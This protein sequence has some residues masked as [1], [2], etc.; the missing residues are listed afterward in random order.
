MLAAICPKTLICGLG[1]A[2]MVAVPAQAH[3]AR[4][5]GT[6]TQGQAMSITTSGSLVTAGRWGWRARC[7]RLGVPTFRIDADLRHPIV[8]GRFRFRGIFMLPPTPSGERFRV[9]T[10]MGGR[11]AGTTTASGYLYEV[12]TV[13]GPDGQVID[14]CR[15]GRVGWAL[16]RR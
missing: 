11:F 12:L 3:A 9:F 1:A 2:L 10:S 5:T 13:L 8:A 16:R 7:S 4:Y 6:T 14:T 15:T